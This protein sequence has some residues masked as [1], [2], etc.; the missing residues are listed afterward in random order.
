MGDLPGSPSVAPS[1]LFCTAPWGEGA[2]TSFATAPILPDGAEPDCVGIRGLPRGAGGDRSVV[3]TARGREELRRTEAVSTP[4][5]AALSVAAELTPFCPSS[6]FFSFLVSSRV[7]FLFCF[8][9]RGVAPGPKL[10]SPAP[11]PRSRRFIPLCAAP[12]RRGEKTLGRIERPWWPP[13]PPPR[14]GDV[15]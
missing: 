10:R 6:S 2:T 3:N 9:A 1:P 8:R 13:S 4:P 12:P 14:L 5:Y 11:G 7:A 15:R